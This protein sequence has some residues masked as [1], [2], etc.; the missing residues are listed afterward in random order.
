MN[1]INKNPLE[2]LRISVVNFLNSKPFTFALN[3]FEKTYH[4]QLFYDV[5]SKCA[6][7]VLLNQVDIGL[8]PTAILTN[9]SLNIIGNYCLGA[10]NE[11]KTVVLWHNKPIKDVKSIVTDPNSRTSNSLVKILASEYWN[12]SPE[13]IDESDNWTKYD[14]VVQIGDN[15][16]EAPKKMKYK[17]DLS[18]EWYK[19]TRKPFVFACWVSRSKLSEEQVAAFNKLLKIGI[20]NME[21]VIKNETPHYQY[22]VAN[23]LTERIEFDFDEKKKE[24][25]SFYLEKMRKLNL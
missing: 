6:E 16:Y 15:V 8:V 17:T 24:G 25:L 12:I 11:V 20:D 5:P 4:Y 10:T 21:T 22:D 14:A 13:W 9:S 18:A 3:K 19:Y 23:Y 1:S 2:K 7:K